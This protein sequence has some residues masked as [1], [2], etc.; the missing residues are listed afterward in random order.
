MAGEGKINDM[1]ELGEQNATYQVWDWPFA[2]GGDP[3]ACAVEL[4][5]RPVTPVGL[6]AGLG[7]TSA[8]T[9][10]AVCSGPGCGID[11]YES[12]KISS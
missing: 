10:N 4:G 9:G 6:M 11:L 7:D 1:T 5:A 8:R 12:T 2:T 3:P